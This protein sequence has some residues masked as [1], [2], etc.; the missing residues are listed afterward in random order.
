MRYSGMKGSRR[1]ARQPRVRSRQI[2]PN[3]SHEPR[4]PKRVDTGVL[5][6]L[7]KPVMAAAASDTYRHLKELLLSLMS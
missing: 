7:V 3:G 4:K 2:R 5:E 1:A 6:W